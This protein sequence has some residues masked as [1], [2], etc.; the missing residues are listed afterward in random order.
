MTRRSARSAALAATLR[1]ALDRAVVVVRAGLDVQRWDERPQTKDERRLMAAWMA[2]AGSAPGRCH[3]CA[4]RAGTEANHSGEVVGLVSGA[5]FSGGRFGCHHGAPIDPET[6]CIV[7]GTM[8][9][10]IC[11]GFAAL[12]DSYAESTRVALTNARPPRRPQ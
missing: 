9:D 6:G 3:G 12:R 11:A 10:R 2:R 7:D 5:L 4:F 1:A 8:P